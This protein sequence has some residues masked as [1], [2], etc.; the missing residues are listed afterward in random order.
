M[1]DGKHFVCRSVNLDLGERNVL[2]FSTNP[3]ALAAANIKF[4]ELFGPGFNGPY[5]LPSI[6]RCNGIPG[7]MHTQYNNYPHYVSE[8]HR[9]VSL[10]PCLC[11]YDLEAGDNVW[12]RP[13]YT[14][15]QE[16]GNT[17]YHSYFQ[18][19]SHIVCKIQC[20]FYISKQF[21]NLICFIK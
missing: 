10:L 4:N 20:R 5:R 8:C 7:T 17:K 16:N 9:T 18:F 14:A 19:S 6:I 1:K 21:W 15:L 2:F 13:H 11:F 3:T 12:D